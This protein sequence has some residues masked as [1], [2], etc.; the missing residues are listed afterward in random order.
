LNFELSR[1]N[2]HIQ[3]PSLLGTGDSKSKIG[4]ERKEMSAKLFILNNI[5]KLYHKW[6]HIIGHCF[7]MEESNKEL[8]KE[9]DTFVDEEIKKEKSERDTRPVSVF[10]FT[11]NNAIDRPNTVGLIMFIM[12]KNG[13]IIGLHTSLTDKTIKI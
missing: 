10:E 9:I 6:N 7:N 5:T 2:L 8:K 13:K 4:L 3:Y 11:V 12:D 1:A